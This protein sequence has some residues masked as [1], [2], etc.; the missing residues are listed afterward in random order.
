[1]IFKIVAVIQDNN[2]FKPIITFLLKINGNFD[3]IDHYHT[4]YQNLLQYLF[5]INKFETIYDCHQSVVKCFARPKSFILADK[6]NHQEMVYKTQRIIVNNEFYQTNTQREI[7]FL[8]KLYNKKFIVNGFAYLRINEYVFIFMRKY[9]GTLA[10][11]LTNWKSQ[12]IDQ[13]IQIRNVLQI[14]FRFLTSLME[15]Q[16]LN[17]MHRDLKPENLFLDNQNLEEAN[18]AIGDFDRSKS[19]EGFTND[20]MTFERQSNTQKYDAPETFYSLKYDIFQYALIILTVAN[21]GNYI[22]NQQIGCK[23]LNDEEHNSYYSEQSLFQF[24]AHTQYPQEFIKIISSCLKRNPNDRPTTEQLRQQISQLYF[25]KTIKIQQVNYNQQINHTVVGELPQTLQ[26]Q[27]QVS[28]QNSPIIAQQ[29]QQ[30]QQQQQPQQQQQQPQQQS[31]PQEQQKKFK[32][33]IQEIK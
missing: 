19:I 24:L 25:T 8:E 13:K 27:S 7:E 33:K 16:K 1:M 21:K 5:K 12:K 11:K 14:S 23:H 31:Q 20:E 9:Y 30:Q 22:G 17:I 3:Q 15:L 26:L 4:P 2:S 28:P 6:N 29:Q 10:D 32:I 18:I